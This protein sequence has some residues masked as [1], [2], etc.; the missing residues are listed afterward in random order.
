MK[1]LKSFL[2]VWKNDTEKNKILPSDE[3]VEING[4]SKMVNRTNSLRK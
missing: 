2:V 1:F 4:D 3:K